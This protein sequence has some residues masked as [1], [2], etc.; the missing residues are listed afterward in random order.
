MEETRLR[1]SWVLEM[2]RAVEDSSGLV[3]RSVLVM[4]SVSLVEQVVG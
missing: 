1:E 2:E 3:L 4:R